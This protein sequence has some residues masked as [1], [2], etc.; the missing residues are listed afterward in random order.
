MK[1]ALKS[2]FANAELNDEELHTGLTM[3]ESLLNSRPLAY[4]END[5]SNEGH[6]QADR[7]KSYA[8]GAQRAAA[9]QAEFQQTQGKVILP[10][11]PGRRPSSVS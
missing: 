10:T 11:H 5:P 7:S 2:N 6:R 3:C 1:K 8:A 4:N 9:S